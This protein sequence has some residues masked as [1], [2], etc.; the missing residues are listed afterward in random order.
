MG[1][2]FALACKRWILYHRHDAMKGDCVQ[3]KDV[4]VECRRRDIRIVQGGGGGEEDG[5]DGEG[6]CC[7]YCWWDGIGRLERRM[8]RQRPGKSYGCRCCLIVWRVNEL[9]EKIQMW[10]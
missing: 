7:C 10:S 8:Q 4:L 9:T 3:F 5:G 1:D 6:C 2:A